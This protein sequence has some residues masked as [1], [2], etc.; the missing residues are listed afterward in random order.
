MDEVEARCK[1]EDGAAAAVAM[2]QT[3]DA[4]VRRCNAALE[5][6]PAPHNRRPTGKQP[7]WGTI[8]VPHLDV[9]AAVLATVTHEFSNIDVVM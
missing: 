2:E 6:A 5:N 9:T 7:G 8:L 4:I 3:A 1:S